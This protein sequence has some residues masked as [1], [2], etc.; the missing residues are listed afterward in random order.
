MTQTD[1]SHFGW[2]NQAKGAWL[3]L[4]GTLPNI[5]VVP[6]PYFSPVALWGGVVF[7]NSLHLFLA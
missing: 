1:P 7:S 3:L 5:F 6:A 4:K 2:A